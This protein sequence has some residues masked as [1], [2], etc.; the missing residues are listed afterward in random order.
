MYSPF[1]L[2]DWTTEIGLERGYPEQAKHVMHIW[3]LT[4]EL[5]A[6]EREFRLSPLSAEE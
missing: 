5:P 4:L 3:Y 6:R 1:P 2:P